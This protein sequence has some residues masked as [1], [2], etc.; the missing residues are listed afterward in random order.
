MILVLDLGTSRIK[1][2]LF[3]DEATPVASTSAGYPTHSPAP[4]LAEQNPAEWWAAAGE[5]VRA[6]WTA[7]HDAGAVRVISVTGQMHGVVPVGAENTPLGP[8]LTLRD[9]R[10]AEYAA[11]LRRDLG[12]SGIY[13][14]TGAR[15]DASSPPAKFLWYRAHADFY[16]QIVTFLA[17]KDWLRQHL[18]GGAPLTD[19]IDAAGMV[20]YD[21]TRGTWSR[22]MADAAG[23]TL[24]R[25]PALAAPT[26]R[27]GTLRPEASAALGMKA[28]VQVVVGAADDVEFLGAGLLDPGDCLE[29]LGSTGSLLLVVDHPADDPTGT[30]ELYPHL[31]P[32][33]WLIGGSTSSAGAALDWLRNVIAGGALLNL[34]PLNSHAPPLFVPYLAGERSP[35]WDPDAG[36][37]FWGLS[38]AHGQPDLIRAAFEGVAFSLRHLLDALCSIGVGP[39]EIRSAPGDDR[40]WLRL[41]A[42]VYGRPLRLLDGGDPTARGAALIAAVALGTFPDL[43]SAARAVIRLA[44]RID[45]QPDEALAARYAQYLALSRLILE[46]VGSRRAVIT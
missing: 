44:E 23:I 8:C 12:E 17:P 30:L 33:R 22:A 25:L 18:T 43:E 19:V 46:N 6:L 21:V 41:R 14:V 1:A 24:N 3:T 34:P 4:G 31:L 10:S 2:S 16:P 37:A 42:A 35:V 45:A 32:G 7:G 39:P 20:I 9:R 27:A 36:A 38:M 28:G 5:A 29:H 26:D 15:L 40:D 11:L 13:R